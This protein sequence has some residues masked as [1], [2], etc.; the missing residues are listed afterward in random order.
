MS[1]LRDLTSDP[2]RRTFEMSALRDLMSALPDLMEFIASSLLHGR[3]WPSVGLASDTIF[4]GQGRGFV[5]A[6]CVAAF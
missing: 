5:R 6:C 3:L 4:A 1:A 2:E